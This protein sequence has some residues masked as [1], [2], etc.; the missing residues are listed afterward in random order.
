MN[1]LKSITNV[2]S[3]THFVLSGYLTSSSEHDTILYGA[4]YDLL[5]CSIM[6]CCCCCCC[7]V[8]YIIIP[9]FCFVPHQLKKRNEMDKLS[10]KFYYN[11][12]HCTIHESF[13]ICLRLLSM[14][15]DDQSTNSL[16]SADTQRNMN[17]MRSFVVAIVQVSVI[18]VYIIAT[19]KIVNKSHLCLSLS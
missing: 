2:F 7:I 19:S 12:M 15:C 4:H 3:I 17:L 10:Y 1:I 13:F 8:Y 14:H 11:I 5:L 9:L 16:C 18:N 6:Y